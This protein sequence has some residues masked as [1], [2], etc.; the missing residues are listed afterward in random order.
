VNLTNKPVIFLNGKWTRGDDPMGGCLG[1]SMPMED[2]VFEGLRSYGTA[3]GPQI[4]K[5]RTHFKRL[6]WAASKITVDLEYSSEEL[7]EIAYQLLE[8]NHLQD[9]YI[10][11]VVY[12]DA[13]APELRKQAYLLIA[14]W[15][16]ERSLKNELLKV[17]LVPEEQA[18]SR[19][20]DAKR[21]GNY[22]RSTL[23]TMRA[24]SQGF[25]EALMVNSE[26]FVTGAPGANFFFEKDE[27]LYTPPTDLVLPGITRNV[28]IGYAS[29]LGYQ[30]VERKFKAEDLMKADKAF[31]TGTTAEITGIESIGGHEF[32]M[33]WE[34]SVGYSLF[35]MY[36]QRVINNEFRDFTLV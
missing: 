16:C 20:V 35:L 24:R 10:R 34:E 22:N 23:A 36:R 28:V 25:D 14:A 19:P 15:P 30:V 17:M 1:Q 32:K 7:T 8:K 29:E 2:G 26:G 12:R 5:A 9:A 13:V 33:D 31:F 27:V 4:F 3:T 6:H 21:C 18:D 11:T